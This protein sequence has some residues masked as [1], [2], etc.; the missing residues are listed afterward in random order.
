M[1]IMSQFFYSISKAVSDI[2]NNLFKQTIF[3][4]AKKGTCQLLQNERRKPF[5]FSWLEIIQFWMA[6][7]MKQKIVNFGNW[8]GF[9]LKQIN[10]KISIEILF[11]FDITV[12]LPVIFFI[13]TLFCILPPPHF[14][15]F[16]FLGTK[17][18]PE[19]HHR[20]TFCIHE[21]I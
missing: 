19:E 14:F 4:N 5:L 9:Y 12:L 20:D 13:L 1:K 2:N 21:W 18:R 15:S 16:S 3:G 7:F 8:K 10:L 6:Y 11:E 17:P